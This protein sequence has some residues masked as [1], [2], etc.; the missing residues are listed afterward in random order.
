MFI[1]WLSNKDLED[2]ESLIIRVAGVVI[3]Q[4]QSV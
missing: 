3:L 4:S 2:P 1:D